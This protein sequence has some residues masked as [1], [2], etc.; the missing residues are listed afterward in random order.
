VHQVGH[1]PESHQDA[2]STK[3][4]K[5]IGKVLRIW[6]SLWLRSK[7]FNNRFEYEASECDIMTTLRVTHR[8]RYSNFCPIKMLRCVLI[9]LIHRI[10]HRAT[11]GSSSKSKWPWKVTVFE[12]IRDIEAAQLK[13]LTKEDFQNCFRKWQERWDKCVR[14]EG[15]Y[16]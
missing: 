13:T 10:W 2:R 3:H 16:Y 14:S 7:H 4:K 1:Y 11:S 15:E 9:H 5:I 12:S 8:F 6:T